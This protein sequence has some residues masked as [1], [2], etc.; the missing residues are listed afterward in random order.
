[1]KIA[2]F[3]KDVK[4]VAITGHTRPDG[5]CVGACLALY[6][7]LLK[8][9]PDVSTDVFLEKPSDKLSFIKYSDRIINDCSAAGGHDLMFCLDCASIDRMGMA[10][11]CF[12]KAGR[13]I[14]IDHHVSNSGYADE[15]YIY[16]D[17]SSCCEALYGFMEKGRIDRDI[18]VALYTGIVYDTG[19]FQYSNTGPSTLRVA[20]E[21]L[22]YGIDANY[23]VDES[24]FA[25]TYNEN[26]IFGYAVFNSRLACDGKVIYT[27][28]TQDDLK[29][30]GVLSREL[31]GI[32]A[33]LRLTR[34]VQCAIC[35]HELCP[36]EYRVS[37]RSNEDV[38]VNEIATLFGGG[39]HERAAGCNM[40]G[41]ARECLD[42]LIE[43]LEKVVK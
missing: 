18:A 36:G 38:D 40:V 5:D 25:K 12:R 22:E 21:L 15:N 19:V 1:M 14:C 16:P 10:I 28:I 8:N 6:G 3:M 29:E 17:K 24:F 34:G 30:F 31:E 20:A 41:T 39:G 27:C 33:Q 35:M 4:R 23:I 43:A 37:L 42:R 9:Y 13:T 2:D 32:V 26:R 7:Y 11:D